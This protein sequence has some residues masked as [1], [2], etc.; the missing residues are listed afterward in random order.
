MSHRKPEPPQTARR[1]REDSLETTDGVLI[2]A[3]IGPLG[4]TRDRG[5]RVLISL[6]ADPRASVLLHPD[7]VARLHHALGCSLWPYGR[8]PRDEDDA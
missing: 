1:A 5:G 2:V 6:A 4:V 8:P 3:R 7:Q